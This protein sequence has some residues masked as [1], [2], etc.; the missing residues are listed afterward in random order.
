M[1]IN[2]VSSYPPLYKGWHPGTKADHRE[3]AE[4]YGQNL[5]NMQ[6]LRDWQRRRQQ[7]K[8]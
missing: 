6:H 4:F 5:G 8:R 7:R 1:M 3:Y 2:T